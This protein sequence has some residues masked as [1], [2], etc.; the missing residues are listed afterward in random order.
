MSVRGCQVT[1]SLKETGTWNWE[2]VS[3]GFS[4]ISI[5]NIEF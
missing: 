1:E 2:A 4:G 3:N 5:I